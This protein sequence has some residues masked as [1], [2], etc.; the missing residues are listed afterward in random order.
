LLSLELDTLACSSERLALYSRP[1]PGVAA[2]NWQME[3]DASISRDVTNKKLWD[4]SIY[5]LKRY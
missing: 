2:S 1:E 5:G 4:L 3:L